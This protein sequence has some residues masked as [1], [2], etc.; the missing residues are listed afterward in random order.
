MTRTEP[1]LRRALSLDPNLEDAEQQIVSIDTDRGK[2]AQA[3]QEAK[4]MVD[5]H[6]QSGVAH[7]T[8]SYVLRYGGASK[9]AMDECEAALRLDPGNYQF[10]SCESVFTFTGQSDR[11]R[12]FLDLDAGSEFTNSAVIGLLLREGKTSEALEQLRKNPSSEFFH[13]RALEACYSTPHPAD[14]DQLME[15]AKKSVASFL[16][17]EPRYAFAILYNHCLGNAYTAPM[18]KTVI[19]DG[20]CAYDYLRLDPL[21]ADFRKSPDYPAL[22]DQAKQCRDKFLADRSRPALPQ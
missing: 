3:Y 13:T 12:A 22:L 5:R 8:L 1:A 7:F 19:A 6:P 2:L 15:Q 9:E 16:D 11:A 21:V 10:R 20:Y 17:P 4:S 14:F 18:I